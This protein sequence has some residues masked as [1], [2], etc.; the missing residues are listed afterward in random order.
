M[1]YKAN[2]KEGKNAQNCM[3]CA[4]LMQKRTPAKAVTEE[5]IIIMVEEEEE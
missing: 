2:K 4:W 5:I 1:N 3:V